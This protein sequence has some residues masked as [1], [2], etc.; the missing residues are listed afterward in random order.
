MVAMGSEILWEKRRVAIYLQ[1]LFVIGSYN[2]RFADRY[3]VSVFTI[4][5]QV[6][7]F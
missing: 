6:Y 4:Y 3:T 2:F 1:Y 5:R 7:L